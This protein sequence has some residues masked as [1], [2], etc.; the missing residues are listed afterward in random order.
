MVSLQVQFFYLQLNLYGPSV[1]LEKT[2]GQRKLSSNLVA[3]R[4]FKV[5]STS[6][7]FSFRTS[8]WPTKMAQQNM[9]T[10]NTCSY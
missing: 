9:E 10:E 3:I 7:E 2:L 8:I 4:L 5:L 1:K 6:D